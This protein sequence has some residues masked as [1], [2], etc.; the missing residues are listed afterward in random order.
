LVQISEAQASAAHAATIAVLLSALA[1]ACASPTP[2]PR[3]RF[4]ALETGTLY[5]PPART[6]SPINAT[7]L[8]ADLSSRGFL[9]GRQIV[10]RTEES[11][12]QVQR[13]PQ[14][15][16]EEPP[17]RTLAAELT[18]AIRGA[19]L[20]KLVLGSEQ[21]ARNDYVLGGT[22]ERFEHRPTAANPRVVVDFTLTLV[23]SSD[24]RPLLNKRYRGE[25]PT[26]APTPEAMVQAFNRLSARLISDA[27][28]DL[29][30]LR[31]RL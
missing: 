2:A 12:L 20:F 10:F 24:R 3:D 16:W 29:N 22:L 7:L 28:A 18:A 27:F 23:R 13:Y 1:L 21:R 6:G 19:G 31:G 5:P 8:I 14:L 26:N 30:Q 17:G 9:G 25:E 11:P 15:L 4:F